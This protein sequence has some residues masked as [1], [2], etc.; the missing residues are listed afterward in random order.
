ML[1]REVKKTGD[2]FIEEKKENNFILELVACVW[3]K[4]RN[5]LISRK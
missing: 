5:K 4:I 2:I 1:A 3:G